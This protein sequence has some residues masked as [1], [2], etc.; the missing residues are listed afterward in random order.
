MK[1]FIDSEVDEG[2][3]VTADEYIRELICQAQRRKA[4]E[5]IEAYLLEG[6]KDEDSR[7][8][9]AEQW[10]EHKRLFRE[11]RLEELRREIMIGVEELERGEGM[12]ADEVFMRL[13]ARNQSM[14]ESR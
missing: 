6:L 1:A 5:A 8:L 14:K 11:R 3:Y 13:R 10:E 9:S 4:G 2:G 7:S 12:P